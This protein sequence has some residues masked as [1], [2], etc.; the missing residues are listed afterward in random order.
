MRKRLLA[1]CVAEAEAVHSRMG[2]AMRARLIALAVTLLCLGSIPAAA[3]TFYFY[4]GMKY[5]GGMGGFYA[6]LGP[7]TETY[8][9]GGP[10]QPGNSLSA[11]TTLEQ[12]IG[13]SLTGYYLL[14]PGPLEVT[15]NWDGTKTDRTSYGGTEATFQL[16]GSLFGTTWAGTY[17]GGTA[18]AVAVV[19]PGQ[20]CIPAFPWSC[21]PPPPLRPYVVHGELSGTAVATDGR[22]LSFVVRYWAPSGAPDG[23]FAWVDS[24]IITVQTPAQAIDELSSL[25]AAYNIQQGLG[26]SLDAKLQNVQAALEAVNAGQREDAA[27]KLAAFINAVEAQR[28][29]ELTDAQADQL[30]ALAR[31]ILSA[32]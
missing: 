5:P 21:N 4:A 18:T 27:S 1:L 22:M 26:G 29:K 28:G 15:E 13:W 9:G 30:E 25:V 24:I 16:S 17:K 31:R 8:S 10:H 32:L 11:G 3:D 19:H 7:W 14:A 2:E 12:Y 23:D 6:H 20:P